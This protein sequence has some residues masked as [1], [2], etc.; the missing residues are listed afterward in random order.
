MIGY[1]IGVADFIQQLRSDLEAA[2]LEG[3]NKKLRFDVEE[4]DV[5]LQVTATVDAEASAKGG[6]GL[7]LCIFSGDASAEAKAS[8]ATSQIQTVR[9]KLKAMEEDGKGGAKRAKLTGRLS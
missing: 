6:G 3:R 9:L 2:M 4:L 8:F 1:Q 5:E 7:K